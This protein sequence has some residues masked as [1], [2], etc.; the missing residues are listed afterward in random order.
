FEL[1]PLKTENIQA[2]RFTFDGC[3]VIELSMLPSP[4]K[5]TAAID[6]EREIIFV[7]DKSGS[8]SWGSDGVIPFRVIQKTVEYIVSACA[9]MPV[10]INFVPFDHEVDENR[11]VLFTESTLISN[12]GN[13]NSRWDIKKIKEYVLDALQPN[14]GTD[15]HNALSFALKTKRIIKDGKCIPRNIVL[16]TDGGDFN[17]ER[18]KELV[19]TSAK[20]DIRFFAVGIGNGVSFDTIKTVADNGNGSCDYIWNCKKV[21]EVL[22]EVIKRTGMEKFNFESFVN[23]DYV[24]S[25]IEN[26]KLIPNFDSLQ[27]PNK[28]NITSFFPNEHKNVYLIYKEEIPAQIKFKLGSEE[29]VIKS[30]EIK[31]PED[32]LIISNLQRELAKQIDEEFAI[33][34]NMR[35]EKEHPEVFQEISLGHVSERHSVMFEKDSH[36]KNLVI[37][38]LDSNLKNDLLAQGTELMIGDN[39]RGLDTWKEDKDLNKKLLSQFA[40]LGYSSSE[41]SFYKYHNY[42]PHGYGRQC[43]SRYMTFSDSVDSDVS[44]DCLSSKSPKLKSLSSRK[45]FGSH[46]A[47]SAVSSSKKPTG[48][49]KFKTSSQNSENEDSVDLFDK[50]LKILEEEYDIKVFCD[51]ILALFTEEHFESYH[52]QV[53]KMINE[54]MKLDYLNEIGK[55]NMIFGKIFTDIIRVN[56]KEQEF[57]VL[58]R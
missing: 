55:K 41:Q 6:S 22:M 57:V 21:G 7:V 14:G 5:I 16:L 44:F 4:S 37:N 42:Y 58:T 9:D 48:M 24:C 15:I 29:I 28:K 25:H 47:S 36:L 43:L 17:V 40:I 23:D 3:N 45:S 56:K 26:G 33:L 27:L 12:S 11:D 52:D 54:M 51:E 20:D 2:T 13:T 35:I 34:I 1:K 39:L 53:K 38:R 32:S 31:T 50:A 10:H 49:N 30:E 18:I 8:M 19:S 46:S